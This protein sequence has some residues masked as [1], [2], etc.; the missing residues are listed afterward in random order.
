MPR[1]RGR[2]EGSIFKRRDGRWEAQL[3]LGW[4]D[5]KRRRLSDNPTQ[6][7]A[8]QSAT[9]QQIATCLWAWSSKWSSRSESLTCG[10]RGSRGCIGALHR[11]DFA[12]ELA[13]YGCRSPLNPRFPWM[14]N[15]ARC[16][17]DSP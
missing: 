5:G 7:E 8:A 14:H 2:N 13:R 12:A 15:A 6:F 16:A 3:D 17:A 4:Q 9:V 11:S 1:R 10:T